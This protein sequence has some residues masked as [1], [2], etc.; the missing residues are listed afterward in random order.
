MKVGIRKFQ[1]EDIPL[2]VKWIN[3]ENNNKYLHYD[4]PLKE[5]KTLEWYKRI[6]NRNDRAD[7]TITFDGEPAGLIGLLNIEFDNLQAEY[8]ICL[9]EEKFKGKGIA[10]KATDLLIRKADEI[11]GLK[12][13]YLYT[14][15]DN[16]P[17]QKLF[18]KCGFVKERL[19]EN[20]LFYRGKYI[21][22]F[23]YVLDV[24]KYINSAGGTKKC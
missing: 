10:K 6:K 7:F 14:E 15:I 9:G 4:L 23:Y 5:N 8:Y 3:D 16:I 12:K 1:E 24:K 18:E 19:I 21:D 17:A 22:R 2:K 13:I 11:Y 20:D